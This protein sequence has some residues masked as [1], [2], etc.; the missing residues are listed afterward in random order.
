MEIQRGGSEQRWIL[1]R[2]LEVAR[3]AVDVEYIFF[4]P[5]HVF[6]YIF[7]KWGSSVFTIFKLVKHRIHVKKLASI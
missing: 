1:H 6:K 3:E 2:G 7:S 4:L 5:E